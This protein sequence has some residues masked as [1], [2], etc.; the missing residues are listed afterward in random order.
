MTYQMG[1]EPPNQP[2][3]PP[4]GPPNASRPATH[5]GEPQ[6]AAP[7]EPTHAGSQVAAGY[8]P[9]ASAPCG[10]DS[11]PHPAPNCRTASP[12]PAARASSSPT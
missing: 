6:H 1:I 7:T 10:S 9:P 2:T 5:D 3:Y 8:D 4:T 11:P 12:A